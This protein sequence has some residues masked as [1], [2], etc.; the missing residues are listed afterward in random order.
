MELANFS[1]L[2]NVR[3]NL[4]PLLST[5]LAGAGNRASP[6]ARLGG[7]NRRAGGP[8]RYP[9][10]WSCPGAGTVAERIDFRGGD[11]FDGNRWNDL[12]CTNAAKRAARTAVDTEPDGQKR[13][14]FDA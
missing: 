14:G 6:G 8:A 1:T 10:F 9:W 4:R 7:R 3:V 5:E 12:H 13:S 11:D 2:T